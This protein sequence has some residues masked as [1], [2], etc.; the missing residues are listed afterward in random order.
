MQLPTAAVVSLLL[1]A[2]G[3]AA[4]AC[5]TWVALRDATAD[6]S[7]ILAKN[8]DRPP[9]EAQPL[10][11]A[12]R[13]SHG[14]GERVKCTY[15][16]VPQAPETYAHIGSRIWWAFGYE[17]GMNEHGVAIGNEAV[18]SKEPYQWG[19]GLL[20]MD[21]LRLA[22][23]RGRTAYQAMHVITALLEKYGQSG[24][25]ERAGEWGKA[26][27]HNSFLIADPKE[28]WVL[29][30]AGRYWAA[31]K[32]TAGVYSISNI[33]S[34]EKDWTEAHPRLVEH[35][36]EKGWSRSAE[37]FN[38]ARDYGDYW[39]KD[40]KNPGNMQ[41]RR[42]MTLSCLR[43]GMGRITPAVMM[44][45]SR[46]HLEGTVAEPRWSPSEPFW[47]TPCLHDI[48]GNPY[49][50]AASMV[51]QLRAEKPALLRQV[52]WSGFSNPCT[53]VFKPFYLHG[54]A[55]PAGYAKGSSTWAADSPWWWANRVKLLC[56]LN[57]R[58]L[59][60]SVRGVFDPTEA[61]EMERQNAIEAEAQRL[62]ERGQEAGA[63]QLLQRFIDANCSRIEGEYRTLNQSLPAMLK[64]AVTRYLFLDYVS[65]WT[66]ASGVPLPL[67]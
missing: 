18:W 10:V 52:Y 17:H 34:I 44:K 22:L 15:I 45:T 25:C 46:N 1:L 54:P 57:Y 51:A 16:E 2:G 50:T 35:A 27:N 36:L 64:T 58:A 55:V 60:P 8:S 47:P 39:R 13:A 43:A 5:D 4:R 20:G 24:D 56:S 59:A 3:T 49:H 26:N 23:E 11:Y 7:V 31:K 9:M 65:Q 32:L 12:P 67:R 33:Y 19:D 61:W 48:A 41:I 6:R 37:D 38:F 53:D 63:V 21:L 62:I 14:P 30:T 40:A 42:N 29:E 66:S 28:A